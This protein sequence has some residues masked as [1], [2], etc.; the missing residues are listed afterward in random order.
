M[1]WYEHLVLIVIIVGVNSYAPQ[2]VAGYTTGI[3]FC[4]WVDSIAEKWNRRHR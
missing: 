1:Q 2:W 4:L 3:A